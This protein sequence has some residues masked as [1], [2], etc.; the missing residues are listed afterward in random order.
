MPRPRDAVGLCPGSFRPV[1][2]D[3]RKAS[4]HVGFYDAAGNLL[5]EVAVGA[6]PHEIAFSADGR[7]LFTT[8]NGVMV[9][10]KKPKANTLSPSSISNRKSGWA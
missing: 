3:Y 7:Y 1:A 9:M 6:H 8:D 2:R 5:K 4:G 10:P